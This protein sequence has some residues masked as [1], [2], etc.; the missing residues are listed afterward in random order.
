MTG[1]GTIPLRGQEYE[2]VSRRF[3]SLAKGS[4]F[5]NIEQPGANIQNVLEAQS[6]SR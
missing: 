5:M 1:A 3:M 2:L 4:A 6:A